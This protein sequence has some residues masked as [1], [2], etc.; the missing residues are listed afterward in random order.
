MAVEINLEQETQHDIAV[1]NSLH[2]QELKTIS[3]ICMK[4]FWFIDKKDSGFIKV[5]EF[6]KVLASV[7]S[8][9]ITE[10]DISK[11]CQIIPRNSFGRCIYSTFNKVLRQIKF[12]TLRNTIIENQIG[13]QSLLINECKLAEMKYRIPVT[14]KQIENKLSNMNGIITTKFM[15]TGL[16]AFRYLVETLQK[17]AHVSLG[18]LQIM[19]LMSDAEINF[20]GT[21]DYFKFI[22]KVANTIRLLF[23]PKNLKQRAEMIEGVELCSANILKMFNNDDNNNNNSNNNNNN[24]NNNTTNKNNDDDHDNNYS[25]NVGSKDKNSGNRYTEER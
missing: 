6:R 22:P 2:T 16:L 21:V 3:D 20:D 11:I 14:K 12:W 10:N 24:N 7:S 19:V 5:S 8:L 15:H 17:S 23:E 25:K 9:G 13:I 4:N 1:M 18:K